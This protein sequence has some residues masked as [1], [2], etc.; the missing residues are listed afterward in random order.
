MRHSSTWKNQVKFSTSTGSGLW[1]RWCPGSGKLVPILDKSQ[2]PMCCRVN[3]LLNEAES[4]LAHCAR[5]EQVIRGI[6]VEQQRDV[7]MAG[8]GRVRQNG[9][10]IDRRP[11]TST[12]FL[13]S[14]AEPRRVGGLSNLCPSYGAC[15]CIRQVWKWLG[16]PALSTVQSNYV[17]PSYNSL[18]ITKFQP[19]SEITLTGEWSKFSV[20]K[21]NAK[22]SCLELVRYKVTS[23]RCIL[24]VLLLMWCV[25]T[26]CLPYY[27]FN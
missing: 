10:Q 23:L 25:F 26:T 15:R 19:F 6:R 13:S 1:P 17:K 24:F 27:I 18:L 5:N 8:A 14:S 7:F 16:P 3:V 20:L 4:S 9:R 22:Q 2:F 21:K 11:L 12:L